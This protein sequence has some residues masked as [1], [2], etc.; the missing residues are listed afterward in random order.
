[1]TLAI[2]FACKCGTAI[3]VP[4]VLAGYTGRCPGCEAILEAPPGAAP[5][6][7]AATWNAG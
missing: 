3:T 4:D 2:H 5:A 1:M 7:P 6:A